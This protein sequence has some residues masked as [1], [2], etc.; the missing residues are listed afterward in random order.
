MGIL[1][2]LIQMS[3]QQENE[4]FNREMN[5]WQ[6]LVSNPAATPE[7]QQLG[8]EQITKLATGPTSSGIKGIG[9]M[10]GDMLGKKQQNQ[11]LQQRMSQLMPRDA[12]TL[13]LPGASQLPPQVSGGGPAT[14]MLGGQAPPQISQPGQKMSDILPPRES[15]IGPVGQRLFMGPEEQADRQ[16]DMFRRQLNVQEGIK[17]KWQGVA[18]EMENKRQVDLHQKE[19]DQ[20]LKNFKALTAIDPNTGKQIY[21]DDIAYSMAFGRN[22]PTATTSTKF[23]P[24]LAKGNN[25]EV[26]DFLK[27][28]G[29]WLPGDENNSFKVEVNASGKIIRADRQ[30]PAR[31]AGELTGEDKNIQWAIKQIRAQ[32]S[33]NAADHP[34]EVNLETAQ[35]II[36]K[37]DAS[38][39]PPD[40]KAFLGGLVLAGG[41]QAVPLG[42]GGQLRGKVFTEVA[43]QAKK[44]GLGPGD[45]VANWAAVGANKKALDQVQLLSSATEAYSDFV[46]KQSKR[47]LAASD[48]LKRSDIKAFNTPLNQLRLQAHDPN[49]AVAAWLFLTNQVQTEFTRMV[50]NPASRASPPVRAAAEMDKVANGSLTPAQVLGV[51]NVMN[52]ERNDKTRS[53]ADQTRAIRDS[54]RSGAGTEEPGGAGAA[55]AGA[56][57]GPGKKVTP[58]DLLKQF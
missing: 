47:W 11:Q 16:I 30:E 26:Q 10:F 42:F 48:R 50:N 56:G 45:V 14:G 41:P 12:T 18:D 31:A 33:K 49:G 13:Q 40:V 17:A 36:K 23:E 43:K 55:G 5:L 22:P 44:F 24:G 15:Q 19:Y 3:R 28:N 29:L 37:A 9:K 32:Q 1:T 7:L 35:R 57:A 54:I 4:K 21:P 20:N 27:T 53:L 6:S 51:V 34:T 8:I 25:R 38:L 2:N 39:V 52:A 58:A 46:G